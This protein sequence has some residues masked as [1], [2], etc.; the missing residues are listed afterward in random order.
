MKNAN[1]DTLS[2]FRYRWIAFVPTSLFVL[3]AAG[4]LFLL[5]TSLSSLFASGR[6]FFCNT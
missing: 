2:F 5:P 3:S 1:E 6:L 4:V